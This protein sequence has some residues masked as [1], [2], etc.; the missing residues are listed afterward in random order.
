MLIINRTKSYRDKKTPAYSFDLKHITAN[1]N[2][3]GENITTIFHSH[4]LVSI[5]HA[6]QNWIASGTDI[7]FHTKFYSCDDTITY[8]DFRI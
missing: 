3:K 7:N 1:M 2:Y 8:T 6:Y 5:Q 4:K